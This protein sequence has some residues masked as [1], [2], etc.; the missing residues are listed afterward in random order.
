LLA[1]LGAA[2]WTSPAQALPT[3]RLSL[4]WVNADASC[5]DAP[6]LAATVERTLGRAA[7]HGDA[8]AVATIVGSARSAESGGH[9]AHISLLAIDGTTL[10]ERSL[11]TEG[12]C[13]RLDESIAVVVALMVDSLE[14]RARALFVPATPPRPPRVLET[15]SAPAVA[16]GLGAGVSGGLLPTP[17]P[18]IVLRAEIAPSAFMPIALGARVHTASDALVGGAGGEFHASSGELSLCPTATKSRLRLGVCVGAGAGAVHGSPV[19]LLGGRSSDLPMI[20]ALAVPS[21]AVRIAGPVWLRAEAGLQVQLL[22]TSW[23]YVAG[24]GTYV[25][26]YQPGI[27]DAL[28]SV[29]AE[30][31]LD[32]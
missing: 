7:F 11:T 21:A 24:D 26:V 6:T 16:V 13:Q 32:S 14:E 22:R 19:G 29:V 1:A 10:S 23:G 17:T 4:V 2:L 18:L 9:S 27:V 31:R 5:I 20:F 8:P 3:D 30:L 12:D 25:D 28:A 15:V